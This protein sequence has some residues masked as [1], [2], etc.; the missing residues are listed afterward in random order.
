MKVFCRLR[1][2]KLASSLSSLIQDFISVNIHRYV[3]YTDESIKSQVS[4]ME[5]ILPQTL[6][7]P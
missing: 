7:L 3:M 1:M 2:Y 5:R 6:P 4:R